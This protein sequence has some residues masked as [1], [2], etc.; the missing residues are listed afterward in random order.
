M[1]GSHTC[2]INYICIFI[3]SGCLSEEGGK[4]AILDHF[5]EVTE[6]FFFVE[7][8]YHAQIIIK[9]EYF[10]Y[11]KTCLEEMYIFLGNML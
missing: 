3:D 8:P 5:N 6:L 11:L 7:K 1:S 10:L 9:A 4:D 2:T